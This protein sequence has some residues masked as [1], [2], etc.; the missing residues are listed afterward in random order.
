MAEAGYDFFCSQNQYKMIKQE[1]PFLSRCIDLVLV[2]EAEKII[3][4]EY[5]IKNWRHAIE[6]ATNHKLGADEAYIC[7]PERKISEEL[8]KAIYNAG[9]GLLFYNAQRSDCIYKAIAPPEY[10]ANVLAFRR[11]LRNNVERV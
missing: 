3:S 6:Q 7:L 5:K 11:M 10:S 2:D 4:I 8:R 1:V 9:L